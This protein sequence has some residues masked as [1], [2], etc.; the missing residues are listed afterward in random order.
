[1]SD[2][3]SVIY[4]KLSEKARKEVDAALDSTFITE[5]RRISSYIRSSYSLTFELAQ[6]QSRTVEKR[7]IKLYKGYNPPENQDILKALYEAEL[8]IMELERLE[9]SVKN[10]KQFIT[11]GEQ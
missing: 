5:Y 7:T 3:L 10:I 6:E 11:K 4:N 9:E 2:A 1:M 8:R